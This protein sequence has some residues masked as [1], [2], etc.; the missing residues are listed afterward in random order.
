MLERNYLYL[1][2]GDQFSLVD[3]L[4]EAEFVCSHSVVWW[5]VQSIA[6]VGVFLVINLQILWRTGQWVLTALNVCF[7]GTACY[8]A[9]K[10]EVID[11]TSSRRL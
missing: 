3:R 11:I 4:E 2:Q 10:P 7:V 5:S 9:F 6:M 1:R 8:L